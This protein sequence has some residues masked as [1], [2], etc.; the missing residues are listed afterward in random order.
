MRASSAARGRPQAPR[1]RACRFS[2]AVGTWPGRTGAAVL[3]NRLGPC[4]R[5]GALQGVSGDPSDRSMK[6]LW[7]RPRDAPRVLG[8]AP[9][10]RIPQ[11][12]DVMYDG[13]LAAPDP[14]T[15]T[16][17]TL[18]A[19]AEPGR[20]GGEWPRGGNAS[21]EIGDSGGR[22]RRDAL[23]AQLHREG[24][25]SFSKSWRPHGCKSLPRLQLSSAIRLRF[26]LTPCRSAAFGSS[27]ECPL[28]PL[29]IWV[30]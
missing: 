26:H 22:Y 12:L 19:F 3:H 25:D 5:P 10:R 20:S 18:R 13:A 6:K 7:K 2:W 27:R 21:A 28:C 15:P 4:H 11:A 9:A 24:G 17:Q 29:T 16:L 1:T 14:M 23:A 30:T 8:R